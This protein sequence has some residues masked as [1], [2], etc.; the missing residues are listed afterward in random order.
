[1]IA[2]LRQWL[3]SQ[4]PRIRSLEETRLL[5]AADNRSRIFDYMFWQGEHGHYLNTF[6]SRG[7]IWR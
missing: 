1:M 6:T 5:I 2:A 4:R 3:E 7:G